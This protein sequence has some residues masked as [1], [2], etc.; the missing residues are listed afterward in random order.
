MNAHQRPFDDEHYRIL[1][2]RSQVAMAFSAND[3]A[4]IE[5]NDACCELLGRPRSELIGAY[6]IDLMHPDDRGLAATNRDGLADGS[7]N[8]VRVE[9]GSYAATAA[10]CGPT[11][12]RKP[13]ATR[14][15]TS[16]IG[17][18]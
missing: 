11:R 8:A 18:P 17:N 3:G 14:T 13:S 5:V 6:A 4:I 2:E 15:A 7:V 16:C 10:S 1:F 12:R 9:R